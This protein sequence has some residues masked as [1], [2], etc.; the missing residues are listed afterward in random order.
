MS[1]QGMVFVVD[2]DRAVRNG[3]ALQLE[4][5][6]FAVETFAGCMDFLSRFNAYAAGCLI[7][8]VRMPDM[9]GPELQT[10][11]TC[12]NSNLPIIFLSGFEDIPVAVEV[13]KSGAFDFLT[14]PV[15]SQKLL[16]SVCAALDFNAGQRQ[17]AD[18]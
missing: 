3:L 13:I 15:D 18:R 9:T 1:G 14:K 8:D 17:R 4:A 10:V 6:G 16:N 5:Y 12:R 7:L 2:D 11:L